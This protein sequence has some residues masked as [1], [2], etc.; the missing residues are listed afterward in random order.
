MSEAFSTA[1]TTSIVLATF[2]GE[3]F[4]AAQLESICR[5]SC[6]PNEVVIFDDA[7]TDGTIEIARNFQSTAPFAVHIF[8]QKSN[9]G[10]ARNFSDAASYASGDIL[11][12]CDQDD[13][14]LEKKIECILL[15]FEKHP[16]KLLVRHNISICDENL[17]EI[18]NNYFEHL[19]KNYSIRHF[20]KGCAT[21]IR[22]EL[23]RTVFP[24]AENSKLSHDLKMHA[25]ARLKD[26]YGQIDDILIKH[27]I[28]GNNTSGFII[29]QKSLGGKILSH[30]DQTGF[31]QS[32]SWA[33]ALL[34]LPTDMDIIDLPLSE[35]HIEA[36]LRI[37]RKRNFLNTYGDQINKLEKLKFIT[38][39]LI[40]GQYR[41]IGAHNQYISDAIRIFIK[42]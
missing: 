27:R 23:S 17:I 36:S 4:L 37:K 32:P 19:K 2:N 15:Y 25:M 1:L 22:K 38:Y 3:R 9:V 16:E 24:L 18:N 21:A 41:N 29:Q 40:S 6:L 12:F 26:Q 39:Y 42:K 33:R 28:H 14:W 34:L 8:S 13:Y 11:I 10:Y 35:T 7:S 5:Q 31:D 20:I 30:L